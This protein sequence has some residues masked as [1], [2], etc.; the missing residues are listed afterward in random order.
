M[1]LVFKKKG[2][3]TKIEMPFD[4]DEIRSSSAV[5]CVLRG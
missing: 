3:S 5:L 4:F 2:T 1:I